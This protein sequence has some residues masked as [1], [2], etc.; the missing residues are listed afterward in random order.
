MSRF[1]NIGSF[2]LALISV[3][4]L[5][6]CWHWKKETDKSAKKEE[7]TSTQ[8]KVEEDKVDATSSVSLRI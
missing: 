5:T 8:K 2:F 6:A 7:E 3:F 4:I 1:K